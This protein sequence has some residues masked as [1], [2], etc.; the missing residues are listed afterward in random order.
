MYHK[1]I[2]TAFHLPMKNKGWQFWHV[3]HDSQNPHL[4]CGVT[5]HYLTIRSLNTTMS[6]ILGQIKH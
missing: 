6:D 2:K 5:L 4:I 3:S 1:A